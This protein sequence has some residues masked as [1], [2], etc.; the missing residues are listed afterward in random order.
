MPGSILPVESAIY[1]M[2]VV[3]KVKGKKN[4]KEGLVVY[5]R[6]VDLKQERISI[7]NKTLHWSSIY[8]SSF[9]SLSLGQGK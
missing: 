3:R 6:V 7:N 4:M 2:T 5:R 8:A 9:E 1:T